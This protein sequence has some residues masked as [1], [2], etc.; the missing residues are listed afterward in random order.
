MPLRIAVIGAGHLGRI[1]AKLLGQVDDAELVGMVDPFPAAREL[2]AATFNVPAYASHHELL[3]EIDAAIIAT[4]SD[5][6][7]ETA[8][9]LLKANKH[10]FVEKPL[11]ICPA[12]ALTCTAPLA[13]CR[14]A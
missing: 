10:V 11:T 8:T 13:V 5:L 4:P 3:D 1:H 14:N 2:A 7:A 9:D 12:A 6:H